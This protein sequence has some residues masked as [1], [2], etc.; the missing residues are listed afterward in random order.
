MLSCLLF[1]AGT[2]FATCCLDT[3]DIDNG[4]G[5]Q[6][7]KI[8]ASDTATTTDMELKY[9]PWDEFMYADNKRYTFLG[10]RPFKE[11]DVQPV[12]L[13]GMGVAY[14]SIFTVL[15]INQSNAWWK[16]QSGGW[17]IIEDL[18]YAK[19]LDKFGHFFTAYCMS[20]LPAD[21]LMEAGM[22]EEPS[23]WIG[24]GLGLLYNTYVEVND[25]YAANWGFSP[26]DAI[27]NIAGCAYYMLQYYYPVLQNFTP[28]WSYIPVSW[29]GGVSIN[30]R[31]ATF[32]DDYN[33]TTFWLAAN[34]NNL[35][36]EAVKPYWPDWLMLSAG[37]GISNYAVHDD[38]GNPLPVQQRYMIG[39]DYDWVKIIPESSFGF[40]NYVRQWLNVV[41]LPGPTL[42]FS[43]SGT[44]FRF[45]Y[46]FQITV[47]M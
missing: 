32:I 14:A 16:D 41:R 33:S 44:R 43:S 37:Y 19:F 24:A 25:G 38:A 1:C 10:G 27:A 31:P 28:R 22:A 4:V 21:I 15:H 17:R 18:E 8:I 30:E 34:V 12:P 47:P 26:S 2:S 29:T 9:V 39:L 20:T 13:I 36:P 40:L 11:T 35:L 3:S 23:R 42:E 46:P 7:E 6:T 45:F 5:A